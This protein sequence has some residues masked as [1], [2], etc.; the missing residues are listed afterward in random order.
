M[1][2]SDDLLE[3]AFVEEDPDEAVDELIE[4]AQEQGKQYSEARERISQVKEKLREII[5]L[6]ED[7]EVISMGKAEDLRELVKK[8][9]YNKVRSQ[10]REAKQGVDL[11]FDDDEKKAF[12]QGFKAA[13]E[14]IETGMEIIS[15]ELLALEDHGFDSD[16]DLISFI[17]GKHS[18]I[19]K[20]DLEKVFDAVDEASDPSGFTRK[21]KAKL[22]QAFEPS[23]NIKP[24]KKILKKIEQEAK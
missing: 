3:E 1:T 13:V 8:S 4:E 24:T 2:M 22:L 14:E 9:Q 18:S 7:E 21:Q 16:D 17:Y 12:A 10:L 5:E 19:R 20:S 15:T 6:Y 23:L 11:D